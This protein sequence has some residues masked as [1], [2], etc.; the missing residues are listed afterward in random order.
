MRKL[1]KFEATTILR[2]LHKQNEGTKNPGYSGKPLVGNYTV[3]WRYR[4]GNYRV[5]AKI[6]DEKLIVLTLEVGHRKNIYL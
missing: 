5:I 6:D 1:D 3:K 4:I 2:W